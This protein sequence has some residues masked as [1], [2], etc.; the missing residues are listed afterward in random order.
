M[1][2][3]ERGQS[4]VTLI[5]LLVTMVIV[6]IGVL[7][8][9]GVQV[10]SLQ[11]AR[12]AGQ[13]MIALQAANDMLDRIRVNKGHAYSWAFTDTTTGTTVSNCASLSC[14]TAELA[15]YD[16]VHWACRIGQPN[17]T[18]K[19]IYGLTDADFDRLPNAAG[20]VTRTVSAAAVSYE[21][22]VRWARA[23]ATTQVSV[24][25]RVN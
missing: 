3:G 2:C 12:D 24:K 11:Q 20:Q 25:A 19:N 9:A 22:V 1:M 21:V 23:S 13:R 10:V 17:S 14:S 4:G 7:G 18:C 5:E 16:L 8:V 15:A 6:A